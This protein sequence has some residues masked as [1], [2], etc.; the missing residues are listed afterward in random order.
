MQSGALPRRH[1]PFYWLVSWYCGDAVR[2]ST[3]APRPFYW[4]VY[5]G[6]AVRCSTKA[7]RPLLLVGAL[8]WCSQV[9]YQG[10]TPPS[11]GWCPGIVVMQSDD[12]PR[13]HAPF[14]W[15]VY[16]GDAV[17]RSTKAPRPLLLVGVLWRCSQVLYQGATP[18]ST[19][20]CIVV[21][22]SGALPRR[23]APFYWLVFWYCGDAVRCS[24]KAPRPLLLVGVLVLWW[25]SQA[26]YKGATPLL[27]I[28]VLWWCSQALYQGATP[29]STSL[30]VGVLVFKD[31]VYSAGAYQTP[32]YQRP[33]NTRNSK[34]VGLMLAQRRRR[35][36]NVTPTL[37]QC[38]DVYNSDMQSKK[39]VIALLVKS[40]VTAVCLHQIIVCVK[41]QGQRIWPQVS[42]TMPTTLATFKYNNWDL[43]VNKRSSYWLSVSLTDGAI[44]VWSCF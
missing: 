38:L 11:T 16:C 8:W 1:A 44:L 37:C 29:P 12:L 41:G 7:P 32:C 4:L 23:H 21:M 26:L 14:Y 28:G 35:W 39:A 42:A 6:D 34:N 2:C 30:L 33:E 15:L 31:M 3:K 17:R 20:W 9:L 22:Q 5:C 24:T 10:A 36:D 19:G 27:L 25:C 13:R 40:A 43:N 18:P